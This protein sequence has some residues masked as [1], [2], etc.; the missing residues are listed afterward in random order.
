MP[1]REK[2]YRILCLGGSTTEC[3]YLDEPET[4]VHL[5]GEGLRVRGVRDRDGG[6]VNGGREVW[7]GNA[8]LSG[9]FSEHHL[10]FVREADLMGQ[11]DCLVLLAG[12][13]DLVVPIRRKN[14]SE[15]ERVM[16][17]QAEAADAARRAEQIA[18]RPW[19]ARLEL[20]RRLSQAISRI[21]G[22][23]NIM[24]ED[25]SGE[26]YFARRE[27]R[28]RAVKVDQLPDLSMSREQYRRNLH[29]I[30]RMC[31]ERQ[32]RLV[33]L[34]QPVLW[35]E[36]T[37]EEEEHLL[38]FGWLPDGTYLTA[39][40]LREGMDEFNRVM[41]EVCS[42]ESIECVDLSPMS[43]RVEFFYDDC[44]FTEAGARDVARRVTAALTVQGR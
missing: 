24:E 23:N 31:R 26:L 10:G 8:G 40:R 25:I 39:R 5:L 34:T 9:C 18:A 12:V 30:A 3:L 7:V 35:R 38:W 14:E 15:A 32:V 2:A 20:S 44:H 11:V 43:G 29:E 36:Q 6:I 21:W 17:R 1:A 13:N 16:R 19:L 37:A 42:S 27:K 33:M 41:T 28:Q 22:T 4:W